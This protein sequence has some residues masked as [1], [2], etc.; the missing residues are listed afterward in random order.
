MKRRDF[1]R[2][3]NPLHYAMVI[4]CQSWGPTAVL[5]NKSDLGFEHIKADIQNVKFDYFTLH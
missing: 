2:E 4:K 3:V 5:T 1:V